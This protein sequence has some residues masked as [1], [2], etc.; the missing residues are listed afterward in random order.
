MTTDVALKRRARAA[1]WLALGVAALALIA[2]GWIVWRFTAPVR[3]NL[4]GTAP[5][6]PL[7][8]EIV[9]ASVV[10][11]P[12]E[13]LSVTYRIRNTAILPVSAFGRLEFDP[14]AGEA[15]VQVF[16]TQCGGLNTYQNSLTTNLAVV[17]RVQAAGFGGAR[18]V[19]LRHRFDPASP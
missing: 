6:L 17:F 1:L 14:P 19:T 7:E 12:G 3:V 10:A 13:V 2:G 5:G 8:I 9:P 4:E 16:L 18:V 15:Q 11:R